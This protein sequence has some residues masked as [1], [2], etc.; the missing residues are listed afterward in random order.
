[1]LPNVFLYLPSETQYRYFVTYPG[2]LLKDQFGSFLQSQQTTAQEECECVLVGD[3]PT[4]SSKNNQVL[5]SYSSL[6]R[7]E[8]CHQTNSCN[9]SYRVNIYYAPFLL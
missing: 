8:L 9:L 3:V 7:Y 1:M 5:R 2:I 6:L 4:H